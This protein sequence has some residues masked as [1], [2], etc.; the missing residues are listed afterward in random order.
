MSKIYDYMILIT[1]EKLR[2]KR[3]FSDTVCTL[4][5]IRNRLGDKTE[6]TICFLR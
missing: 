4:R 2:T 5:W 1:L 3:A 6:D